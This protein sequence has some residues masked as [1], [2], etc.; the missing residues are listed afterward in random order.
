MFSATVNLAV[1][2]TVILPTYTPAWGGT[3]PSG[4]LSF[5]RFG[6]NIELLGVRVSPPTVRPGEAV[7]VELW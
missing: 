6:E 5:L 2:T 3:P 4:S 1:L 7:E